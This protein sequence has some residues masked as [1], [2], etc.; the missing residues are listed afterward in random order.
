[1]HRALAKFTFSQF[2]FRECEGVSKREKMDSRP[3]IGFRTMSTIDVLEDG[4]KWRKY[5]KK[6]VKSSPNLRYAVW[7]D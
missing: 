1:M 3:R 2:N 4:Y 7:V 5:G 6:S